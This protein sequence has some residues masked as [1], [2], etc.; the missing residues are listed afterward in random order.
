MT[1]LLYCRIYF[2]FCMM[3]N[4]IKRMVWK[5]SLW[6]WRVIAFLLMLISSII[7]SSSALADNYITKF[8]NN[9]YGENSISDEAVDVVR[10]AV[11]KAPSASMNLGWWWSLWPFSFAGSISLSSWDGDGLLPLIAKAFW[12][13]LWWDTMFTYIYSIVNYFLGIVFVIAVITL[14]YWFTVLI[15]SRDDQDA[16]NKARKIVQWCF[17]AIL[18]MS[19]AFFIVQFMFQFMQG[20]Q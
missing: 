9:I 14:M 11:T 8:E 16:V 3:M 10:E 7:I 5:E 13:S 20:V 19:L 12:I 1:I 18:L 4:Q 2:F 17:V 6:I 15:V